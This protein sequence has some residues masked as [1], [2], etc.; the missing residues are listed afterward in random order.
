MFTVA[1]NLEK[2]CQFSTSTSCTQEKY[3]MR[4]DLRIDKWVATS[5]PP[6]YAWGFWKGGRHI[7]AC[8]KNFAKPRPLQWPHPLINSYNWW[9]IDDDYD[10]VIYM[11]ICDESK[12]ASEWLWLFETDKIMTADYKFIHRSI[13]PT[14]PYG[15]TWMSLLSDAKR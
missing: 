6:G 13:A 14:L 12:L 4:V 15:Y 11:W 3:C 1:F 10:S 9:I 7:W 8:G 2:H 5:F